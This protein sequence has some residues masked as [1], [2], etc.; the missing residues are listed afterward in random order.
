MLC[1]I[2]RQDVKR[3]EEGR[4]EIA[5]D[6]SG[7]DARSGWE[8]EMGSRRCLVVL[9]QVLAKLWETREEVHVREATCTPQLTAATGDV[10]PRDPDPGPR[11]KESAQRRLLQ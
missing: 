6:V 1:V 11:N 5:G 2:E 10:T 9:L 4:E 3:E 8:C 7:I